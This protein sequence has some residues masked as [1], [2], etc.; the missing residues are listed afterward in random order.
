MRDITYRNNSVSKNNSCM[1]MISNYQVGR[2]WSCD[3]PKGVWI[4]CMRM[5]VVLCVYIKH[6]RTP[7]S[8]RCALQSSSKLPVGYPPTNISNVA[9]VNNVCGGGGVHLSCS[10]NDTCTNISLIG[11]RYPMSYL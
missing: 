10:A 2:S 5:C 8:C 3:K 7:D 1:S 6:C 9:F 4:K 11:N